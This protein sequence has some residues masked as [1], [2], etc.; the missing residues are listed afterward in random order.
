[1]LTEKCEDLKNKKKYST[2]PGTVDRVFEIHKENEK[3]E[4]GFIPEIKRIE[5]EITKKKA[6]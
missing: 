1:M 4:S 6:R 2:I 3:D 5:K